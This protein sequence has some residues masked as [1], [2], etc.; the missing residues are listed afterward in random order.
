MK[1]KE[2]ISFITTFEKGVI[3]QTQYSILVLLKYEPTKI[4]V[5]VEPVVV[6]EA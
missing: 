6:P 2:K 4:V 5:T 1:L 3:K